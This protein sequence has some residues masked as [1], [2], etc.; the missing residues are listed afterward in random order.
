MLKTPG[1]L[2]NHIGMPLSIIKLQENTDVMV[3]EMGT[4]RPGDINEL[5][6]IGSPDIG[7][8]TN[9]GQEHLEGFG[10]LAAVREAELELSSYV[11]KMIINADD[12]FLME[13]VKDRFSGPLVRFGI[14]ETTAEIGAEGIEG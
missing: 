14:R 2:N 4:N 8:I 12:E 13:G 10:S 7:V 1:N 11:K 9:I 3:L 5:C 6:S